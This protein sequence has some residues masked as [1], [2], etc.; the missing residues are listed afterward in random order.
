MTLPGNKIHGSICL[1]Q[2]V[3][4]AEIKDFSYLLKKRKCLPNTD[5]WSMSVISIEIKK[6]CINAVSFGTAVALVV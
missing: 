2:S 5:L 4:I 3:P 1:D 6:I